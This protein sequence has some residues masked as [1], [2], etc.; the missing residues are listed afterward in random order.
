MSWAAMRK[1]IRQKLAALFAMKEN[2][3]T[4][5]KGRIIQSFVMLKGH[6][7]QNTIIAVA[8]RGGA[9]CRWELGQLC[10]GSFLQKQFPGVKLNIFENLEDLAKFLDARTSRRCRV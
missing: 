10:H 2:W 9:H 1:W 5:W 4:A 8:I 7:P 3:K 6:D